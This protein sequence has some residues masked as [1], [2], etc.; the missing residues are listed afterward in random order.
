VP[1]SLR[2]ARGARRGGL[3]AVLHLGLDRFKAV[4]VSLG[5]AF[6]DRLLQAVAKRLAAL[7]RAEDLAARLGGDEF[8]VLLPQLDGPRSATDIAARLIDVIGRPYLLEGHTINIGV[9][10]GIA[11]SGSDGGDADDLLKAA[12]LAL[13]RAKQDGQ[14]LFRCFEPG[15]DLRMQRRRELENALRAALPRREFE[16]HFQPLFDLDRCRIDGFEALLRW[17]SP[18]GG[19]I[20]PGDFVPLA[21]ELG[22]IVPIGRWVLKTAC[23]TTA[24][25]PDDIAVAVNLS[26]VQFKSPCL[27]SD[28]AAALA[29]S[30]LS[31]HRLQLEITESVLM[32][33]SEANLTILH[34]FRALGIKL[35]M[36]DFG[37]GYA[38]LSYLRSFPFDKIKIDQSFVRDM[39][40][41]KESAAIVGAI[42]ALA[43]RLGI[44]TT[45]EGV[46]TRAQLR[47]ITSDGCCEAQGYLIGRPIP[48]DQIDA[49]LARTDMPAEE[50]CR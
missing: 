6:G 7:I 2:L 28:V 26:P 5:H 40:R 10:I 14:N 23:K 37:T 15:M 42:S 20:P 48:A 3:A 13:R 45:A 8:G 17:N 21:E 4:N 36:D 30:G 22:L 44:R 39:P 19:T 12:D 16:L 29:A 47:Q 41:G 25:W 34:H 32:S 11:F 49:L 33:D 9:S 46:E 38:S 24:S 18:S 43:H 50:D 1:G 27:V 35:A 31:P